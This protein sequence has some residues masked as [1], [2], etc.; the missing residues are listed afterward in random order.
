M[1]F[2]TPPRFLTKRHPSKG[3]P[4]KLLGRPHKLLKCYLD[5]LEFPRLPLGFHKN[6]TGV[7]GDSRESP[8]TC[9]SQFFGAPK[10]DSQKGVQ[11]GN[12]AAIRA[13]LGIDSRESGHLS[14][15]LGSFTP[16][17]ETT[18]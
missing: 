8:Q 2:W 18:P 12:P 4:H 13:N 9:D 14:N 10:R 15:V 16:L 3:H 17:I 7:L 1:D 11:F 6:L 5:F